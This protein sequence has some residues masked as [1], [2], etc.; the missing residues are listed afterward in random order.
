MK[1]LVVDD[2]WY[3]LEGLRKKIHW[4]NLG[5]DKVYFEQS[6]AKAKE[7]ATISK[8]DILMT[9]IE[10][11][12]EDGIS[13]ASWFRDHYPGTPVI[14]LTAH[15]DFTYAKNAIKYGGFDYILQP[16]K[17][18]EIELV[19]TRC[20]EFLKKE[21]KIQSLAKKG[22]CY[23]EIHEKVLEGI[24]NALFDEKGNLEHRLEEW[25]KEIQINGE[26]N[27]TM[28]VLLVL[29]AG[30]EDF[31]RKVINGIIPSRCFFSVSE[32]S[33]NSGYSTFGVLLCGFGVPWDREMAVSFFEKIY[34]NLSGHGKCKTMI[35][36][37]KCDTQKLIETIRQ[38]REYQEDNVMRKAGVVYV[39]EKRAKIKMREPNKDQ[40]RQWL[41]NGDGELI[42]NQIR[43]LLKYAEN[44]NQLSLEY[45]K[46]LFL[47]F[48]DQWIV[49]CYLKN[50]N[51]REWFNDSYSYEQFQLAYQT[52]SEINRAV[53]FVVDKFNDF[54]GE[55]KRNKTDFMIEE[56][57]NT[58]CSYIDEN[59]EKNIL[60]SEA[61]AIAYL[62]ED[63][64][65]KVFKVKTGYGF[66][67]YI[68]LKKIDYSKRL[69]AETNYPIG[70]IAS[71]VGY[72]NFSNF[73]QLFKKIIGMTPQEYRIE[74]KK[75]D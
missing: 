20:I 9:D 47:L 53:A 14:F 52:V 24:V 17:A 68:I 12:I 70:V 11:P 6:A 75:I 58:V 45:M 26:F 21:R 31:V 8:T 10:M 5:I 15:A 3:V 51:G 67:E 55:E 41:L 69:L 57:I 16:A 63:Y 13:L 44:E 62:S 33:G 66:K 61:A 64:F 48:N 56:R 7:R 73:S 42:S 50:I 35:Y 40:W 28:P 38:L 74:R 39:R 71:K 65:S 4:S 60:R 43:N 46:K 25:E 36:I 19:L 2:Q 32:V 30:N 72:D 59:L 49:C 18:E 54:L 27:W 29:E 22:L 37:G 23:D 1:I 34:I